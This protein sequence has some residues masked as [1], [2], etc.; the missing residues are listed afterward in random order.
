VTTRSGHPYHM[1]DAIY[2]QPGA[3]RL[4][5]RANAAALATAAG[6][7][8]RAARVVLT[9]VGSSWHAARVGELLLADVGGL[10]LRARAIHAFTLSRYWP[11]LD[12][13]DTLIAV[14]HRGTTRDTVA[15][16]A[17]AR[18]AGAATI[19]V[20]GKDAS[21]TADV[22]L[23]TV[24]QEV[25]ET[26]TVGYTA[27]L[28][29]LAALAV[30]VGGDETTGHALESIPDL[31][32]ML[33]GQESWDDLAARYGERRRY[34]FVGGGP[35]A[36]TADEAA[37]KMHE[38]SYVAAYGFDSEE[39]L[40]GPWTAMTAEDALFMV[41]PPGPARERCLTA[42]RVARAIGAPVVALAHEDDR[43]IGELAGDV[44]ALPPLPEALS[45]LIGIVPLQLF[46]YHTALRAGANPDTTRAESPVHARARGLLAP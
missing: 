2:A 42:A 44:L 31:L 4:L 30:A 12:A 10:G 22:T 11:G 39:F 6:R 34:Y 21:P 41:A 43:E 29:L 37:L 17:A 1:H 19:A 15:A 9:G 24:E 45:P 28:A 16:L 13:N 33:L 7:V 32:A 18:A 25:S 36:A 27:A 35:N 3:L 14:S 5:S 40:H 26:H 8:Q 23:R 20:V 46:A 38:T